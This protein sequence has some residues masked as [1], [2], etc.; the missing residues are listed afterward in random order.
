M[1]SIDRRWSLFLDRDGVL[2]ARRENDY[3]KCWDEFVFLP[4]VL[5]A[6]PRFGVSFGRIIVVTNQ[7]GIGRGLMSARALE[8]IH[9][10]MRREIEAH[11]GRI[12]RIFHCPDSTENDLRGWRKPEVGMALEAKRAFPEIDFGRSIMI[13]DSISDMAFGRNAGMHT[14]WVSK[15]EPSAEEAPLIDARI[16]NLSAAEPLFGQGPA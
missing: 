12:D 8:D 4:G 16:E 5:D 13:G 10:R 7:R 3:V 1:F 9:E 11:G 2:N 6:M 15:V 14:L